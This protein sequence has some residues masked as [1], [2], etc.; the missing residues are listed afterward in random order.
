MVCLITYVQLYF[1]SIIFSLWRLP[2]WL[3]QTKFREIIAVENDIYNVPQ[4]DLWKRSEAQTASVRVWIHTQS[5]YMHL[6]LWICNKFKKVASLKSE[7]LRNVF[8]HDQAT[9]TVSVLFA[10]VFKYLKT[11]SS[12]SVF[13]ETA[14]WIS[15]GFLRGLHLKM[16]ATETKHYQQVQF[17]SRERG[18]TM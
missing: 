9:C 8:T 7:K 6:C 17:P 4:G 2:W 11:S 14:F 15:A 5:K 18:K 12:M 3:P 10:G 1:P 13:S 16:L